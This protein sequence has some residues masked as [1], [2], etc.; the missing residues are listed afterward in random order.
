MVESVKQCR[1]PAGYELNFAKLEATWAE[2]CPSY[3][4][5][6]HPEVRRQ[7]LESWLLF[8]SWTPHSGQEKECLELESSL[9][10]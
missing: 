6:T 5:A 8:C 9:Y 3:F 7:Q 10:F 1:Y 4:V 2:H